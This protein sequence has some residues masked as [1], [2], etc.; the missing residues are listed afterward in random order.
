MRRIEELNLRDMVAVIEPGV[1]FG[2]LKQTLDA[3]APRLTIGFPLSPPEA[4]IAANCLLD[5]LGNL[6]LRHGSMGEWISG[7]EVVR[8]DGTTLATGAGALGVPVPV[9]RGPLPDLTGLFVSWQG[10]TGIVS[11]LAVQLWPAPVE[12]ERSFVFAHDR[13]AVLAALSELPRLDVLDDLAALSWPTGK[14]LLGVDQP[15]ERD[16]DEPEFFLYL[17]VG[18]VSERL[19]GAKRRE[20]LRWLRDA[21]AAGR[22]LD[23]PIDVPALVAVEPRLARFAEFP[24]R[25]DFLLDHPGGGLTWVGTYGPLS[26]FDA[27]CAAGTA[28]VEAHGFPPTIVARPMKGGH[29]GVL[30]FVLLFRRDDEADVDRVR[31]CTTALCDELIRHGFVMYK[32]P[33][34]AVARYA[35]RL[36]P[37]FLRLTREVK[38]VLDPDG[39]MNPG[40]W[41]S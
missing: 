28:I 21:R 35:E 9:A 3:L 39:I 31:R 18:A 32:T 22:R 25:L 7:L 10:A 20:L 29:Y 27:A 2:Q 33:G 8:A 13:A 5:G 38:Q 1:T 12:R 34:W 4:S 15:R 16:P 19:L 11:R 30:R 41:G 23:D 14:M 37:G 26:R 6:S 36:D 24:T 17:D 40:R